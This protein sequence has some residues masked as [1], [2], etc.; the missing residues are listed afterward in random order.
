MKNIAMRIAWRYAF[1]SKHEKSIAS[2][3]KICFFSI[4]IGSFSLAL[5]MAIM[6]GIEKATHEKMQGI[7]AQIIIRAFGE[8]LDME[9]LSEA[10]SK[11][12]PTIEAFSPTSMRQT[13]IQN[14]NSDDI[15]N[16]IMFKGIDPQTESK[17]TTFDKKIIKSA[18]KQKTLIDSVFEDS[19][20][21]GD[22]LAKQLGVKI[23]DTVN[24]L[25]TQDEQARSRRITLGRTQ[26]T[27]GGIFST[28]IDEFDSALALCTLS[29]F[30]SIFPDMGITQIN[31][32][33]KQNAN[34][35][36]TINAL[37]KRSSDLEIYSWKELYPALVAALKLEKYAMFLVL[38]L[39]TLVASM[40]IMSLLFMQITQKRGDIAILKTMGLADKQI[41]SI[42]LRMG[43]SIAFIASILGLACACLASWFLEAFPLIS[44]P[45]AYYVSHLPA[46]MEWHLLLIIFIVIM[47]IS[48]LATW[49]PA[50]RTRAINISQVLRF[51]A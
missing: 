11:D 43:M 9:P 27:I 13:I 10:L 4:F 14:I 29:F 49:L 40:N 1:G 24:I 18:H 17:I 22:K 36:S 20:A 34:E 21:I 48:Y 15:T 16:V 50:Q 42:F 44:L 38:A 19:I 23:G 2:M 5:V 41:R 51:E 6:N 45:D 33:L 30:D 47:I 37:K 31:V 7:H 28:G 35:Q 12:F 46:H 39:I 32:K 8:P 25:F 3:I 26:A